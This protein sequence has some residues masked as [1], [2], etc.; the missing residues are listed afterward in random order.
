MGAVRLLNA[1][2]KHGEKGKK[3]LGKGLMFVDAT[4]NDKPNKSVMIDTGATYNFFSELEA[5]RLGLKLEKDVGRM[6]AV[7][8]KALATT[9]VAKGVKVKIDTWEGQTDLVVVHMDNFDVVLGM[10]FLT[11]KCAIPIPA[12]GS[13]LIMGETPSMVPAKVIPPPGVKLLSALQFKKGV[14]KQEPTYVAVPTVFEETVEEIVPLEITRVLKMNGDVMLDKLP[15]DLPPRRGIDHQIELVPGAKPPTKAPYRMASPELEELRKQINELL[16]AGFIR[17]SKVP[18]GAPVLFQKKHD[19]SLRLCID[20]MALNKVTVRNT[21]PIPLIADLFDQL[22]R[23]KYVTKLDLRSG[24][25]QVRIADGDE[26]KTTCIT[27][28][29]AFEF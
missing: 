26:P 2:K 12:T 21:Y 9:G 29:G 4:I 15:N 1:L 11:E 28:Y 18:F 16:E 17:P 23:A 19:G 13:L 25:Y 20:Y 3:T 7:N 6:K 27:R 10:E 22:S 8:S 24:Y 14:K 5:K